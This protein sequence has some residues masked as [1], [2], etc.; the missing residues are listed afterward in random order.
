MDKKILDFV[1]KW[2]SKFLQIC[3][4]LSFCSVV[5]VGQ[6]DSDNENR[7]ATIENVGDLYNGTQI[8]HDVSKSTV[9]TKIISINLKKTT[10]LE[11]LN[12]IANKANLKVV[13]NSKLFAAK[14]RNISLNL[15]Q[16]TVER[17][18]WSTLEGTGLR[19]AISANKQ[20]V[21]LKKRNT[22]KNQPILEVISGTVTEAASG[23]P[24]PGANVAIKGT[25]TG[26]STDIEG[27]YELNV[28]SLQDTLVIS[29]I[30]Y[31]TQE[32]PISGR[33]NLDIELLT[34]AIAG[35]E[36]VV[37]GYGSMQNNEVTGSIS[38]VS[39]D[40]IDSRPVPQ[41]SQALQGKMPGVTVTQNFESPGDD[42]ATIRI[43]GVGTLGNANP[44]VL[45][46]GVP[47]SLNDINT[48]DIENISVLKDA[49]SAAIYGS[50]AANGVVLVTTKRGQAQEGIAVRYNASGGYQTPT[51]LPDMM[52]GLEYMQYWNDLSLNKGEPVRYSE[53]HIEEY[54]ANMGS[55]Q[56]PNVDWYDAILEPGF[57]QKHNLSFSGGNET[58]RSRASISYMDQD[59]I[60]PNFN[61]KRYSLRVNSDFQATEKLSFKLNSYL[62]QGTQLSPSEDG[63]WESIWRTPANN[64]VLM[65]NGNFAEG[66]DA[67]ENPLAMIKAGGDRTEE[68]KDI[69][70]NLIS[71]YE[72]SDNFEIEGSY[73]YK[74]LNSDGNT[75]EKSYRFEYLAGGFGYFPGGRNELIRRFEVT[76]ENN[77]NG[78]FKYNDKFGKHDLDGL[79]GIE[80][81]EQT[82]EYATASREALPLTDYPYISL[83]SDSF[84][85]NSGGATEWALL[86][87]FGRVN[88][89]YD[90]R[91]LI[92]SNIRYDGSSRFGTGNKW[93][94]FPS[95][96]IGWRLTEENF[97]P[98]SDILTNLKLRAS[99][100]RLGN[101][102]INNFAYTSVVDLG[103]GYPFN[104]SSQIGG[105][106]Q[107]L[108]NPDITWESTETSNV[109]ADFEFFEGQLIGSFEL[110]RKITNDILY[111]RGIPSIIGLNAP[112]QNIAKVKNVGWELSLGY[113]QSYSNADF[114]VNFSL[115]D[116]KNEIL[117]LGGRNQY[118]FM[119]LIEGEEFRA[120]YGYNNTGIFRTEQELE[121][122]AVQNDNVMVGDLRFEDLNGDGVINSDDRTVIGST[123]PRYTFGVSLN[124]G[125]RAFDLNI[126]LQGVAKKDGYFSPESEAQG[127][128][129]QMNYFREGNE[130]DATHPRPGRPGNQ[131]VNSYYIWD[132]SYL[133]IKNVTLRYTLPRSLLN[134]TSIYVSGN[135]LFTFTDYAPGI[136]PEAPMIQDTYTGFYPNV[137]RF[138]LGIDINF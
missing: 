22:N 15:D 29:F 120:I 81:I 130:M 95:F 79:L 10:L 72:F 85:D 106:L 26:T 59:G 55:E 62:K 97:F 58:I 128:A 56:Y 102:E 19:F 94:V 109:G 30:G 118:S 78:L 66:K 54:R 127:M 125:Y 124:G 74:S 36:L 87:Y 71:R 8:T 2:M 18:L 63:V 98:D 50:R 42:D 117:E 103:Q 25:T 138:V 126:F 23:S 31:Q 113:Q 136:D 65:D 13:Y 129:W 108:S 104:K 34:E 20:L 70:L 115:S 3:I 82:F 21:L 83:G 92:S 47:G 17:A 64:Q 119:S 24:L 51:N 116:V 57:Q 107:T 14:D 45:I 93:G 28:T 114:G 122:A 12:D 73:A 88:Y 123:I 46:D 131:F 75:F 69:T 90:N 33:T 86:S 40:D 35:E 134:N 4:V 84:K 100:G 48:E 16:V 77:F 111:V 37:V 76:E 121:G 11:A 39:A 105:A 133:R 132:A 60:A 27:G 80:A 137:Q 1:L 9:L 67:G 6:S 68:S 7:M 53:E 112:E 38:N 32:V 61:F 52:N 99:W 135:N 49:S 43:R 5:A 41:V 44:L 101:Q 110:Y 91:Y 89:S 96:S